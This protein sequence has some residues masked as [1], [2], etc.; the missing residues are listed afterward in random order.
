M[1][2]P[3]VYTQQ[4]ECV[5]RASIWLSFSDLN[6]IIKIVNSQ[7]CLVKQEKYTG[8]SL[9]VYHSFTTFHMGEGRNMCIYNSESTDTFIVG[10][11]N[12]L[13]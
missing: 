2:E 11:N 13:I 1:P 5:K 3:S 10:N 4:R 7:I 8:N 12:W 9:P 6:G